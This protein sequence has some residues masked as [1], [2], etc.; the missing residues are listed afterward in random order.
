MKTE[1]FID[2]VSKV[3]TGV[4]RGNG[5]GDDNRAGPFLTY[6]ADGRAHGRTG[7]QSIVHEDH[8]TI[9]QIGHRP[10]SPVI[11]KAP[12]ELAALALSDRTDDM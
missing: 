6:G 9:A 4:G 11:L 2:L 5:N 3:A 7:R 8:E 12:L 1:H 10:R